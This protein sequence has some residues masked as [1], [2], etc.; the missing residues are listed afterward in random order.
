MSLGR[1]SPASLARLAV[2]VIAITAAAFASAAAPSGFLLEVQFANPRGGI[3]QLFFNAGDG[4]NARDVVTVT[5]PPSTALQPARFPLP[6]RPVFRL[7][8]DPDPGEAEIHIGRIRLLTDTGT[9][10]K[11]FGPECLRPMQSIRSITLSNG[12]ATVLTGAN[13]PMLLINEPLQD[14][15]Q[16]ALGLRRLTRPAIIGLALLFAAVSAVGTIA[17]LRA[18]RS[19]NAFAPALRWFAGVALVVLGARLWWLAAYGDPMPYFDEWDADVLYLLMPL[20][21]G[22]LDWTALFRAHAEHR[23]VF[24]RLVTLG[25]TILNGSWDPRLGMVASAVLF[26]SITGLLAAAAATTARRFGAIAAIAIAAFAVLPFDPANVFWGFQSQMYALTLM[27]VCV[28]AIAGTA[29]VTPFTWGSAVLVSLV[30][31]VTMGSGFVAPGIAAAVCAFRALRER[32]QRRNLVLLGVLFALSTAIGL[33]V[34]TESR[35]HAPSYSHT[36]A[37]F[38][39]ALTHFASWPFAPGLA[40]MAIVWLPW[41]IH[42]VA[43][44][45]RKRPA[46]VDWLALT[47]GAWAAVNAAAL[48]YGRPY[49]PVPIDTRFHTVLSMGFLSGVLATCALFRHL[50]ARKWLILPVVA[51]SLTALVAGF[52]EGL[53]GI[54]GAK[55]QLARKQAYATLIDPY[56]ATGDRRLMEDVDPARSPYWNTADLAARLDTPELQA[57]LPAHFRDELA[58]RPGSAPRSPASPGPLVTLA[59]LAMRFAPAVAVIGALLLLAAFGLTCLRE[60]P[61]S[62]PIPD[63]PR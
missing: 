44:P 61:A 58:R 12:I 55:E 57:V 38:I 17:A 19:A 31:L 43:F 33:A 32:E 22:Y 11:E 2:F 1:R 53:R 51:C 4:Y 56:L 8:F 50:T 60:R 41:I 27:A 7:R 23:I 18:L 20:Q 30:S 13:D 29:V 62:E 6:A 28:L 49:E 9:V 42:A 45:F 16:Q 26:S 39:E 34:R 48:A 5:V 25:G 40:V 37:E 14:A 59:E 35:W 15:S 3:T 47:L 21:G 63:R 52:H 24:T 46:P 10:V 54:D 36:A